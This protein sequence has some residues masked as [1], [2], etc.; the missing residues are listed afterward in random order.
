MHPKG[1]AADVLVLF[2]AQHRHLY[3]KVLLFII[4]I[5]LRTER[6]VRE[7]LIR[8]LSE[9]EPESHVNLAT[10]YGMILFEHRY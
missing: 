6:V 4:I 3:R 7:D 8:I 9:L 10:N 5:T 2:Q 1:R